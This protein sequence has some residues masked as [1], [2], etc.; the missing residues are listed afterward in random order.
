MV[1]I[2][3]NKFA[4]LILILT[5]VPYFGAIGL[6][7]AATAMIVSMSTVLW[8][9]FGRTSGALSLALY[10]YASLIFLSGAMSILDNKP[11]G[12]MSFTD[13]IFVL[14]WIAI[15]GLISSA[16]EYKESLKIL[17]ISLTLISIINLTVILLVRLELW[18]LAYVFGETQQFDY[19]YARIRSVGIIGQPGKLALFSALGALCCVFCM[20]ISIGSV[21][22]ALL[23]VAFG[24]YLISAFFTLSRIGIILSILTILILPIRLQ[25]IIS[26]VAVLAVWQ[27]IDPQLI[28]LLLRLDSSGTANL[29]SLEYR[30]TMRSYAFNYIGDEFKTSLLGFGPSKEAADVLYLPIKDHSLRFPDSSFTLVLFRY[31]MLG[32]I[33]SVIINLVT[34][35]VF[36]INY[37]V[38]FTRIGAITL[39]IYLLAMLLDPIWHD[40]KI[41]IMYLISLK[42]LAEVSKF[43]SA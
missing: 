31:G 8:L 37:K 10:I 2:N 12:I 36:G 22:R 25:L 38:I 7:N 41:I 35:K 23:F 33:V 5:L 32:I 17:V 30:N 4:G 15:S 34:V 3:T 27:F 42:L 21:D 39:S 40:P 6:Y 13:I 28:E 1:S 11:L 26:A 16:F 18:D 20:K 24:C 19:S 29:S 9:C 43:R 14:L